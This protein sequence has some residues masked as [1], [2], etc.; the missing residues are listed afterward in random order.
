MLVSAIFGVFLSLSIGHAWWLIMVLAIGHSIFIMA[1]SATLTAGLVTSTSD[2]LKVQAMG[3]HSMLGFGGG[4]LGPS[5]FGFILDFAGGQK[6]ANAWVWAYISI[7]I[8]GC[9][10]VMYQFLSKS[11]LSK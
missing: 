9:L 2:Q 5:I 11:R 7:A 8:W 10:F 4:L 3:L 1:D 6:Q